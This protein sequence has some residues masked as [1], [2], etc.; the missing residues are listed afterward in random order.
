MIQP[1]SVLVYQLSNP[2]RDMLFAIL[3]GVGGNL[4]NDSGHFFSHSF[5]ISAF[6]QNPLISDIAE[7]T[8]ASISSDNFMG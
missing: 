1:R 5:L 3:Q 8:T 6:E 2:S 4:F 7:L